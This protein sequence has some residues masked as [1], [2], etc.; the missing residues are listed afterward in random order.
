M[1]LE[2]EYFIFSCTARVSQIATGWKLTCIPWGCGQ[3]F[4]DH[5]ASISRHHPCGGM[6][7]AMGFR[8]YE[9]PALPSATICSAAL[10]EVSQ[11]I[12]LGSATMRQGEVGWE[13]PLVHLWLCSPPSNGNCQTLAASPLY[14]HPVTRISCSGHLLL[15][16]ILQFSGL[17]ILCSVTPYLLIYLLL[18][19]TSSSERV[20]RGSQA[21][22][23]CFLPGNSGC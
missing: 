13:R 15:K 19:P 7:W 16:A 2:R 14:L 10:S 12:L 9:I 8:A 21:S 1:A 5:V 11:V 23:L 4:C 17:Q 18:G 6:W 22:W 20:R 3:L